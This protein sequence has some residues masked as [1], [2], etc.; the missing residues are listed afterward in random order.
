MVSIAV[1]KMGMTE[2]TFVVPGMKLNSQYYRD[3]LL[4]QQ[5]LP[6]IKHVATCKRYVCL[7][8]RQSSISSCK[9]TIKQLQEE[10]PDF[11]G[12]DLWPPNSPD[13]NLVDYKVWGVTQQCMNVTW[14]VSM[15]WSCASLTSGTVCSRTL[16]TWPS[17][18]G[19]SNWD[20]A[21]MQMDKILNIYCECVW[22][23]KVMDKLEMWANAQ[24]D[25]RPA[26]YRW[27][28]LFNA[29]KFGWR[30]LLD[31]VQ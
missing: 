28:P 19:E 30:P 16:L 7:S 13:L 4:S 17:T 18:T 8:T 31:A 21:C 11:I 10:T 23:T 2:L 1:S 22:L 15:S 3:V 26:E 20:H 9:D 5:M 29:A 12:P 14:T 27:R 24:R 6:A 25:G